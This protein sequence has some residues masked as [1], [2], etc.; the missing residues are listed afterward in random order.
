M[1]LLTSV[2]IL[3]LGTASAA[4]AERRCGWLSN[5]A[6]GKWELYDAKGGWQIMFLGGDGSQAEGVDKIPDLTA[7]EYVYTFAIHGYA[8]A[9]MNVDA[10]QEAIT[11]IYSVQQL[12]LARC[13]NDPAIQYFLKQD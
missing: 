11:R 6:T 9:C 7:G 5:P 8:C 10:D 13:R 1:K 4:Q 2:I 3:A 12:P